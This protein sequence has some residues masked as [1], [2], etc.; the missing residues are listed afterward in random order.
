[1]P[2]NGPLIII[3]R[4]TSWFDLETFRNRHWNI[5]GTIWHAATTLCSLWY[6]KVYFNFKV[7]AICRHCMIRLILLLKLTIIMKNIPN[8]S[9]HGRRNDFFQWGPTVDF[10]RGAKKVF[11]QVGGTSGEMSF[12]PL[13]TKKANLFLKFNKKMS[14]IKIQGGPAPQPSQRQ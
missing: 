9:D 1:V 14:N 8:K 2:K 5:F 3:F 7:V 10:S 4:K 12:C 6:F 13:E 11:Y